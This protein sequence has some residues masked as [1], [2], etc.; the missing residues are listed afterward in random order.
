MVSRCRYRLGGMGVNMKRLVIIPIIVVYILTS[1]V[2]TQ[3][4]IKPLEEK[5]KMVTLGL[6]QTEFISFQFLHLPIIKKK[7]YN[8]LM[9]AAMQR[10]KGNIDI[11][12]IRIEGSFTWAELPFI[13]IY[14]ISLFGNMQKITATGEVIAASSSPSES[15][16]PVRI[17]SIS[18]EIIKAF[19]GNEENITVA[20]L[21]F[22]NIDGKQSILGRYLAE[23]TI[24]YLFQKSSLNIVERTQ[25]NRII[26]EQNMGTSGFVS[27]ESA[28]KIGQI[29]GAN[30][31]VIGTITKIGSTRISVN[32]KMVSTETST[33]LSSG[34]IEINGADYSRMY[35]EIIR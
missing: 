15:D 9:M 33:L 35:D 17:D 31:V 5:E 8:N 34:L 24:N 25:I 28:V 12:N 32:V 29:L 19:K 13:I 2:S 11:I 6:V 26:N 18:D 10:Y 16:S 1:C 14:P 7:A 3:Y 23:Q 21:D 30:T 22:I 20:V 4:N 27:D